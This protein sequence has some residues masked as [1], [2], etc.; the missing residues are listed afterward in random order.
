M[1]H[2]I[3]YVYLASV[4]AY[5]CTRIEGVAT[6]QLGGQTI[7]DT[8]ARLG[9]DWRRL[10]SVRAGCGWLGV[11]ASRLV[12]I[13][14]CSHS[15]VAASGQVALPALPRPSQDTVHALVAVWRAALE[16]HVDP[17]RAGADTLLVC[18]R[19]WAS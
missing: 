19:E 9:F 6:L 13:R 3:S 14:L 18:L 8:T 16:P 11:H 10:V 1:A 17:Q 12:G 5:Y 2:G 4:L 15:A 7:P